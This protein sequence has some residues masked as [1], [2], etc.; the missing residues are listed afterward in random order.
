MF[1][2]F[3]FRVIF[4]MLRNDVCKNNLPAHTSTCTCFYILVQD[5]LLICN[6][7]FNFIIYYVLFQRILDAVWLPCKLKIAL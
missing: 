4:Y 1:L 2:L 3:K 6:K 7:A 5:S